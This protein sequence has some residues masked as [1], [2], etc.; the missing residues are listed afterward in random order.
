MTDVAIIDKYLTYLSD[1][2]NTASNTL[3]AYKRDLASYSEYLGSKKIGI[4]DADA[5]NISEYKKI[6]VKNGRSVATVSRC[7]SSLRSFY[8][9]LMVNDVVDSN[10]AK[11][12]KNDKTEKKFFEVL[13]ESEIDSILA[14]PDTSDYKGKRDKAMLEVLY[15]TGVKV[16]ELMAL[17]LA[18]VNLKMNYIR[19]K[20]ASAS[21]D[22]DRIILLYPNA[23]KE[24]EDYIKHARKYFVIDNSETALF[25]NVNGERMTRQ[26]FWKILKAYVEDAGIKKSITPQTLRHSFATHLLENGADIHDIKEI[27]GHSDIS[28]TQ[29]YSDF[30]K[31]RINNS[32]LKFH[33]RSR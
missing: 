19:C 2:K 11:E 21:S 12:I 22:N 27:L 14:Q 18:D 1:S 4:K 17:D 13:S 26:G 31:S 8:K 15:A 10:P 6:L 29:V 5:D 23:V 20:S 30:I 28:S 32:Y 24:L 9:Y 16:S 3:S 25:V 33:H 7:M